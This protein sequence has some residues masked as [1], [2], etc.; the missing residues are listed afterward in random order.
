MTAEEREAA[1]QA[2]ANLYRLKDEG[3][4]VDS[5]I[6]E[7]EEKLFSKIEDDA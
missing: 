5:L 6:A 3:K 4:H 1:L 2:L 7:L